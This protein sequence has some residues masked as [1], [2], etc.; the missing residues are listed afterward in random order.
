MNLRDIFMAGAF[1][2]GGEPVSEEQ[3]Q[4]A[5]NAYLEENPVSEDVWEDVCDITTEEATALISQEFNAYYKKLRMWFTYEFESS[6]AC[7]VWIQGNTTQKPAAPDRTQIGCHSYG[8]KLNCSMYSEFSNEITRYNNLGTPVFM[9]KDYTSTSSADLW[10]GILGVSAGLCI[11]P[12]TTD[13]YENGIHNV[14]IYSNVD[15]EFLAGAKLVV[16]GVRV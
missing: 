12:S 1:A 15:T 16:K 11:S 2:G 3:I 13:P 8:N 5:V 7:Q 10:S 9:R 14:L 4:T 6:T